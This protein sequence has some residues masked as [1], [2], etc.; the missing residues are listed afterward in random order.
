MINATIF[1]DT[2]K[3]DPG[4]G[5]L[6][7]NWL[8][9]DMSTNN[10]VLKDSIK[11]SK[12]VA[13]VFS[14]YT[15]PFTLPASKNNNIIFKRF[16]NNRVYEGFD[17]RRKYSAVIKLNGIDYKK[18]FIRLNKV[19]IVDNLP[20]NYSI[21]FFGEISSLKDILSDTKLKGLSNLSKLDFD[22]NDANV[23]LGFETGFDIENQ[24]TDGVK[25]IDILSIESGTLITSDVI[26]TLNGVDYTTS[27]P[28]NL[29]LVDARD[30]IMNFINEEASDNF[31][32]TPITF[33][34]NYRL[35]IVCQIESKDIGPI[36]PA[37]IDEGTS[38]MTTLIY[39]RAIGSYDNYDYTT[40]VCVPNDKGSIIFPL[41]SHTRGFEVS[42]EYGFHRMATPAEQND[43]PDELWRLNMFDLKPALKVS[44]IF[45]AIEEQFPLI[46]FDNTWLFGNMTNR[47]SLEA[48]PIDEMYM[49]LHNKK[50]YTGY[51]N[52]EG[53]SL[54]FTWKRD[55]N[56]DG[57]DQNSSPREWDPT[58][59]SFDA[60]PFN[61][62]P[63]LAKWW[64]GVFKIIDPV[65]DGAIKLK[66]TVMSRNTGLPVPYMSPFTSTFDA[67]NDEDIAMAF[68]LPYEEEGAG[69]PIEDQVA[70]TYYLETEVE[71]D[72]SVGEF[73][74][75]LEIR[76]FSFTTPEGQLHSYQSGVGAIKVIRNLN[77]QGL[78]PDYKV[79]EFL[80]DLFKMYN[81]V[82][83]EELQSDN[84]YKINIMSYDHYI[85]IG[86]VHDITRFMDIS[87]SSVE[88]VAPYSIIKYSF[89]EPK[90]FLA[91]NQK[92]ITGDDFGNVDFNVAKFSEGPNGSNSLLFDGG[93]YD[94][95]VGLEKMMYERLSTVPSKQL[96]NIQ[97]GWFVNDN[98]ENIPEPVIGKPLYLFPVRTSLT[99]DT[100][101]VWNNGH[102]SISY[103]RGGN[104]SADTLQTLHFNTEF[105]EWTRNINTNSLFAN[106]HDNYI[107]SIYSPFAKKYKIKCHLPPM[108]LSKLK[109]NDTVIIDTVS[110][111]IESMDVNITN[112]KS[113]LTL[114]R[115]TDIT[116]RLESSSD[117]ESTDTD[118]RLWETTNT[119][120]EDETLN[121]L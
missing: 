98:K 55:L 74:P 112:G 87:K 54:D 42:D 1:I 57:A 104:V 5:L 85:S 49:W 24:G 94:V 106:Y 107:S 47:S 39:A 15:N 68:H 52:D 26:I 6:T 27:M 97:F 36:I 84:T 48:S 75:I 44:K 64:T 114:L 113:K 71:C 2:G 41:I 120:W 109:L 45:E 14:V 19:N 8:Q 29:N 63:N 38:G 34:F 117:G 3:I 12:D 33:W 22:Y 58:P 51:V 83:F 100:R 30:H 103:H 105:D 73:T 96:S 62:V 95:E 69:Y 65:G 25:H 4:T 31:I 101:I 81:L 23:Q 9:A 102:R 46:T 7:E 37:T 93:K 50:G 72:S 116:T 21:Q 60:R 91:I 92:E 56:I 88:R 108:L 119:K 82:A 70:D 43:E 67:V 40:N 20:H 86:K 66:V 78:V 115:T 18:G 28:A 118:E 53:D 10:I 99:T 89:E 76:K 111:F 61:I 35:F 16:S 77:P 80:K 59:Q 90:T 110:Y 79:I 13:K 121:P 11:Q 17:P 32:A